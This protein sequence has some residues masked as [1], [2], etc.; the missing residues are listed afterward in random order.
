MR[1]RPYSVI[2][3]DEVE[4]AHPEV[5][6]LL[7]QVLD[8]GILTDNKGRTVN[9]KNTIII[10]TS[11]LNAD[12]R[13]KHQELFTKDPKG[14]RKQLTLSLKNFFRPE[15]LN[16]IDEI[17]EFNPL[18]KED[19]QKIIEIELQPI[20]KKLAKKDI[21][22]TVSRQLKEHLA[23]IGYDPD[24]GARPLKRVLQ[25]ELVDEIAMQ[26][27]EGKIGKNDE[28]TAELEG[29]TIAFNRL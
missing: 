20:I 22:L 27:L 4:K 23:K 21:A 2:L 19:L 5:F 12:F 11:N 1:R 26:I 25:N 13:S 7:L 15:F 29:N 17:I 14:Y 3:F 10:M 6:N 24:F 16:R 9:F 28:I 18:K 8:D